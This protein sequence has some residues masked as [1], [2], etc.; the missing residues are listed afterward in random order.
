MI[1]HAEIVR[2]LEWMLGPAYIEHVEAMGMCQPAGSAGQA[3]HGGGVPYRFQLDDFH[4]V[5]NRTGRINAG[6][7]FT[8]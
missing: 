8:D 6:Y 2:R 7:D 1:A 5:E 4:S 3:M